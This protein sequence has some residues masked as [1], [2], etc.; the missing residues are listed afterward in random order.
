[1]FHVE[2]FIEKRHPLENSHCVL[3]IEGLF[4]LVLGNCDSFKFFWSNYD[5]NF[6]YQL[7]KVL[8]DLVGRRQD[9]FRGILL[10]K[11]L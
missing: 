6:S 11:F 3:Q 10:G 8:F 4:S 5:T 2:L 1:M 7:S 9:C